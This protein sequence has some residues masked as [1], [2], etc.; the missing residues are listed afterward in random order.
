MKN[1]FGND[2]WEVSCKVLLFNPERTRVAILRYGD[3]QFGLPGGHIEHG[4]ELKEAA[5]R[6]VLEETGIRYD[7]DLEQVGF[8]WHKKVEKE[9][10]RWKI[11]LMFSGEI[12]ED[13][14]FV[15]Q[16]ENDEDVVNCE[17]VKIEDIKKEKYNLGRY[18]NMILKAVGKEGR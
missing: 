14:T 10:G 13:I 5:R 16:A 17:W 12:K 15:V 4:E 6:E 2:M 7:G 8:F 3:G 1:E 18:K 9:W 11:I